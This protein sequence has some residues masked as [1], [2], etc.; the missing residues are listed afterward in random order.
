MKIIQSFWSKPVIDKDNGNISYSF[1]VGWKDK[2]HLYLATAL[3]CLQ[4]KK[5]Y[6]HVELITDHKGKEI[7][8]DKLKLPYSNV[9]EELNILDNYSSRLF[10]LGKMLAYSIQTEPFIHVDN[11]VFIWERFSRKLESSRLISQNIEVDISFYYQILEQLDKS[12]HFFPD[13]IKKIRETER[14]INA[15]NAGIIGGC[16]IDF[17]RNYAQISFNFIDSNIECLRSINI[18]QFGLIWEQFL[19]YCLA[20]DK[21]VKVN[22]LFKKGVSGYLY[23]QFEKVPLLVKY[24]HPIAGFKRNKYIIDW[25]ENKLMLLYPD[26][27]Y[28]ILE[29]Y[30]G[31]EI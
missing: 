7:F 22:C 6:K 16:D 21:N 8:I 24:V 15:Y 1:N 29:L 19:F 26:T 9:I 18:E 30:K 5:Y 27:Y 28:R 3:S 20:K 11:D 13:V 31:K 25:I 14:I 2:L 4:L 12:F 10:A 23:E 17:F